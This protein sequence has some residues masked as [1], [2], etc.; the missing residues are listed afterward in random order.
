MRFYCPSCQ[1]EYEAEP[2]ETKTTLSGRVAYKAAC[3][4]CGQDMAEFIPGETVTAPLGEDAALPQAPTTIA[5]QE[6]NPSPVV[7]QE[8]ASSTQPLPEPGTTPVGSGATGETA[9]ES[10]EA[11]SLLNQ[12]VE[13]LSPQVLEQVGKEAVAD[14]SDAV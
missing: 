7:P 5:P 11:Q 12:A 13:S 3:P 6:T 2:T 1:K 10:T 14:S 4:A 8:T 9:E